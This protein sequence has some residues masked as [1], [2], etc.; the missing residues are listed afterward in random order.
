MSLPFSVSL[1]VSISVSFC[2]FSWSSDLWA[3]MCKI[4]CFCPW[5]PSCDVKTN[6]TYMNHEGWVMLNVFILLFLLHLNETAHSTWQSRL[7]MHTLLLIAVIIF[8]ET[9]EQCCKFPPRSS[10][11]T[12]SLL[13][14]PHGKGSSWWTIQLLGSSLNHSLISLWWCWVMSKVSTLLGLIHTVH[15]GAV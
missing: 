9:V 5:T 12:P 6:Y 11:S 3:L 15:D 14:S 4:S 8:P 7:D 1:Y 10:S 13:S 2:L